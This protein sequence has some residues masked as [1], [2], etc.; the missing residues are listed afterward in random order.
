MPFALYPSCLFSFSFFIRESWIAAAAAGTVGW[1]AWK[2]FLV[3]AAGMGVTIVFA[4]V[5]TL[6]IC[7]FVQKT[8]GFRLDEERERMGLDQS[9]HGEHAYGTPILWGSSSSGDVAF[10]AL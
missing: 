4:G 10:R 9:L 5:V 1:P 2:Q 7:V 3:Q 6:I 8:V